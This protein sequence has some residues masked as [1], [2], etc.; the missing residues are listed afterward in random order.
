[1][2]GS[3]II[4]LKRVDSTSN[5]IATLLKETKTVNGM[6]ILADEQTSGRG[7]RG[8]K[9]QSKPGENLLFSFYITYDSLEIQSQQAITQATSLAISSCLSFFGIESNIKWPNDILI[10]NK[11]IAGVLIENQFQGQ[12]IKSSIIGIG[13]NVLQQEFD[14]INSTSITAE[15]SKNIKI[16]EVFNRLIFELNQSFE[17]VEQKS[18]SFLSTKYKQ[19]LWLLDQPSTF[20][21][22]DGT[23]FKGI[24][25]GTDE[26]GRIQILRENLNKIENF[27][28]KEIIFLERNSQ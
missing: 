6:V 8:A 1:M 21:L 26:I 14:F 27:D 15:T 5:Y 22:S 12:K 2:I 19:K 28:L 24:I 18:F 11:K 20:K 9:W 3:E 4:H 13:L 16:T 17:L 23:V 7:Q 25:K 10:G